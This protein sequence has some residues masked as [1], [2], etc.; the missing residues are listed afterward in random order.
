MPGTNMMTRTWAACGLLVM[1]AAVAACGGITPTEG[2][3]SDPRKIDYY[4]GLHVNL[5]RMAQTSSGTFYWDSI[6]GT[7]TVQAQE[8]DKLNVRYMLW[9]PDGTQVP[10]GQAGWSPVQTVTLST[11]SL[12]PGWVHGLTGVVAGTTRQLV[13]PPAEAYGSLGSGTDIPPNAT[14]VFLVEVDQVMPAAS[15]AVLPAGP[16]AAL[17]ARPVAVRR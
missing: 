14:L 9:L 12:I 13:V 3:W 6:H 5:A 2:N 4:A 16:P 7:G 15:S 11:T 10:K 8:G 1:A 17:A